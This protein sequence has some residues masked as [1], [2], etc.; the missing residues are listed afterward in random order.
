MKAQS[1]CDIA[2]HGIFV[3]VIGKTNNQTSISDAD[4]KIETL[5]ST[6]NDANSVDLISRHYPFTLG[7]KFLGLHWRPMVHSF[8][9]GTG[10][11]IHFLLR[12][13]SKETI[14]SLSLKKI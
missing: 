6:H 14:R 8:I 10:R 11:G 1:R 12:L 3:Y 5:P 4:R 7:L 13:R 2:F 9:H